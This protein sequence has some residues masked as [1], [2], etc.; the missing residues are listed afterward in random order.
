[1]ALSVTRMSAHQRLYWKHSLSS[2][3]GSFGP[4]WLNM[5]LDEDGGPV[6]FLGA[7]ADRTRTRHATT[8]PAWAARDDGAAPLG[9]LLAL[10][11]QCT[12]FGGAAELHKK[13]M[14]GLSVVLEGGLA[15][16]AT[17]L[18]AG[19]GLV[20]ETRR[21]KV[22]TTLGFLDCDLRRADTD[23]VLVRAT[24][25]KFFQL[26]KWQ[27]IMLFTPL[28]AVTLP[29]IMK[30]IGALPSHDY[31]GDAAGAGPGDVLDLR[32]D[33][34]I[35]IRGSHCNGVGGLHGG[36]ACLLGEMAALNDRPTAGRPTSLG[37]TFMTAM[38]PGTEARL[39]VTWPK[40]NEAR[41]MIKNAA[42]AAPCYDITV[43]FGA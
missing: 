9:A 17:P 2:K 31:R 22:G 23:E 39:D 27:E 21:L 6:E 36:A 14:G 32:P 1:M 24:H 25:Q 8:L 5:I 37:V 29:I 3:L 15:K 35:K 10:L 41:V 34:T 4:R 20:I 11:D 40:P 38:R 42:T 26:P 33:N 16:S 7:D 12:T 43:G 19:D 28:S 30:Q 18:R 13:G